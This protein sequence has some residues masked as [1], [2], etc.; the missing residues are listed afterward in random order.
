MKTVILLAL[1]CTTLAFRRTFEN[2]AGLLCDFC[3]KFVSGIE[4]FMENEEGPIEQVSLNL[5]Q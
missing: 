1:V 3:V 4:Q 2:K 5:S